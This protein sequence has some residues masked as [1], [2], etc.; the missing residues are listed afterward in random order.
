MPKQINSL[1]QKKSAGRSYA[2]WAKKIIHIDMDAFYAAVEQR[3]NPA[4]RGKPVIVGGN[5][6]SRSVVS[7][8]SY[9]ARK[10]GVHSAMPTSIAKKKC[11]QGIFVTPNFHKY[12]AVS[13]TV[14]GILH[15]HTDIMEPMSLDE[16]YLDVTQHK[17]GIQDPVMAASLIKQSIHAVTQLTASAGVAP[18]C[19]LAKVASDFKKPDG[20][21]VI[22]P[23]E[24]P[25]FLENLPVRKIPGVGPV[26]EEALKKRGI[27]TCGELV[28]VKKEV[29]VR[30]FGKTGL[31]LYER[32][33]GR[34]AREVEPNTLSKQYSSEETFDKDTKDTAFLKEKLHG[35]AD[36]IF[37]GL[38]REGR[39][40]KTVVLKLKYHDFELIT[41]SKTLAKFPQNAQEITKIA[42]ELLE[43]KTEAGT[44]PVRLIGLGISGL[45]TA[46]PKKS[47]QGELF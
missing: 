17:L 7:T 3:D 29:L 32:A 25:D 31:F 12:H 42:C 15:Q 6:N 24:I 34:D 16:A 11:P 10:F 9:E 28:L 4:L 30:S 33:R 27:Q 37:Q 36:D 8:A 23:E 1:P 35:I 40:G 20:L 18:N 22:T 5:P 45:D 21:T 44:R 46:E 43:A 39:M 13:E 19:F 41:R 14:M 26:L 38:L 47:L 2:G